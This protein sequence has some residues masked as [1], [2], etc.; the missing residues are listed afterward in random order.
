MSS[1]APPN[2]ATQPP[3]RASHSQRK[4]KLLQRIAGIS[5]S[6]KDEVF[7]PPAAAI[8]NGDCGEQPER[9]DRS[10]GTD[11]GRALRMPPDLAGCRGIQFRHQPADADGANLHA[12]TL[13]PRADEPQHGN[14]RP[15]VRD[16]GACTSEPSLA[17]YGAWVS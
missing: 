5:I 4:S 1:S 6:L 11:K 14:A 2:F 7:R 17:R 15:V 13:R 10:S 16:G 8:P 3:L 9:G 12:A